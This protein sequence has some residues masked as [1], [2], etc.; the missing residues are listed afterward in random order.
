M[1]RSDRYL[2]LSTELDLFVSELAASPSGKK[3]PPSRGGVARALQKM[4]DSVDRRI[5][6]VRKRA[7]QMRYAIE[8]TR[9][10]FCHHAPRIA[11]S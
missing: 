7:E 1:L 3:H 10:Y 8:A 2:A 11:L 9:D 6:R 5:H 4:T